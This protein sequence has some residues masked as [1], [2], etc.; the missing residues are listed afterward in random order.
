MTSSITS[1]VASYGVYAVFVLM[2]IDAVFP[3]AS[4]LVMLYAGALASGVIAH[5]HPTLFGAS[6]GFGIVSFLVL[7]CSGTAGYVFGSLVGWLIGA[8]GRRPL[9]AAHGRWFHLTPSRLDAA[10]QWFDRH[11]ALAV[12]IGRI[13]PLVRSFI[14]IPAGVFGVPLTPYLSLTLIGS[15]VWSFAFAGA[16]WGLGSGYS[17]IHNAFQWVEIAIVLATGCG[18]AGLILLR[19]RHTDKG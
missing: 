4:E 18:L 14:S 10:E 17:R 13:T 1:F 6:L 16:G 7:A 19:R 11:G 15:A 9:L 8:R 5:H 12:L 3:A 2:A